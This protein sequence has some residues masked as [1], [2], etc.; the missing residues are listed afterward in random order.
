MELRVVADETGISGWNP[1]LWIVLF[2]GCL[3]ADQRPPISD[4]EGPGREVVAADQVVSGCW[5]AVV[6]C[7]S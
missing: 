6:H 3:T 1:M 2:T 5:D 7:A 4:D